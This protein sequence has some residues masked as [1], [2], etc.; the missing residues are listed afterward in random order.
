MTFYLDESGHSGDVVNSGEGFD[1]KGQPFFSLA[2]IGLRDE[3]AVATRISELREQHRIPAGELKSKSLNSKPIFVAQVIDYLQSIATPIF[4]EVVDK[5]YFI[6]VHITG[7]HLLAPCMGFAEGPP[8]AFLRN[9]LADFLNEVVTDEILETFVEACL[10][11]SEALV[12]RSFD[13]LEDLGKN[14][15]GN[16]SS[17]DMA[18]GLCM[19]IT[20]AR[21]ELLALKRIDSTVYLQFLPP[22]DLNKKNKRVWMLPNLTSFTN[23]YARLNLYFGQKLQGV[24]IVHD[25]QLELDEILQSSKLAAEKIDKNG[26]RPYTPRSNFLFKETAAFTFAQSHEGIGL[27]IADVVAGAV[28][29]Y[30]RDGR[31]ALH[32]DL[33]LAVENLIA[34]SDGQTGYG[35]N[36]VVAT[37][38]V[39]NV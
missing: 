32:A 4:V 8:L 5:R 27:Q 2:A 31:Q 28:M 38:D 39:R 7:F 1:F 21:S 19:T 16:P 20:G 18:Q 33:V 3:G 12:M 14:L 17:R 9:A 24:H 34:A 30:F 37:S 29:R 10:N 23:I 15:L 25:Q 11:P 22:P 36:Q 35:V 6:C 26:E 13:L